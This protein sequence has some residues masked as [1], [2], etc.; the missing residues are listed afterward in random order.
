MSNATQKSEY[1]KFSPELDLTRLQENANTILAKIRA[2]HD[3]QPP[4]D[5]VTLLDEAG[6]LVTIILHA[7]IV[8]APDLMRAQTD[9]IV[10]EL[11]L[12]SHALNGIARGLNKG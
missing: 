8:P 12:I 11:K 4:S 5:L 10:A 2:S 1:L 7:E 3:L 9:P 6:E